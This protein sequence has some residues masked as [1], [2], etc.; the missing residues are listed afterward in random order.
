M[1]QPGNLNDRL[2]LLE[3]LDEILMSMLGSQELVEQWWTT[4]NKA[5]DMRP[6]EAADL[7]IVKDYLVWHAFCAG[8]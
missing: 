2:V 7:M 8:G 4:P 5:F 3:R 6:P 1:S